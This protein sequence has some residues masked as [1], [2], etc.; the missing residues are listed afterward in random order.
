MFKETCAQCG[1][2]CDLPR[3]VCYNCK[4]N[5][6]WKCNGGNCDYEEYIC[7]ECITD[8]YPKTKE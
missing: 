3:D 1:K 6:T 7:D 5:P 4:Q 2:E 8:S